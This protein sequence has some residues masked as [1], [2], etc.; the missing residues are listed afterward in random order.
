MENKLQ[1]YKGIWY[2]Y[3]PYTNKWYLS[4]IEDFTISNVGIFSADAYR[5]DE[6]IEKFKQML[7][8]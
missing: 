6:A 8:G 1:E 2:A 4:D 5:V 7:N 3:F